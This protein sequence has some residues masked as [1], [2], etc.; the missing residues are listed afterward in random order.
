[1]L[2][3]IYFYFI[4]L[5]IWARIGLYFIMKQWQRTVSMICRH[6]Q[7]VDLHIQ[8]ISSYNQLNYEQNEWIIIALVLAGTYDNFETMWR[9]E[10]KELLP[11]WVTYLS[12]LKRR[13]VHT[14]KP[15]R[16]MWQLCVEIVRFPTHLLPS[17]GL[18]WV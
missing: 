5:T 9:S 15:V 2:N 16:R 8:E 11:D 1:M 18:F 4:Y 14:E 6:S 3:R 7:F 10:Q 12:K 17:S 13:N